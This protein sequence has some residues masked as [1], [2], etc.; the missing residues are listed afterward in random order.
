MD[1]V[2]NE[3][4]KKGMMELF[5]RSMREIKLSDEEFYLIGDDWLRG[6]MM[7]LN[8]DEFIGKVIGYAE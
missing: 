4:D 6:K 7:V 2:G 3:Y 1:N 5:K 8:E